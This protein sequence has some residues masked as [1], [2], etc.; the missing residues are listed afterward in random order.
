MLITSLLLSIA[1]PALAIPVDW[2]VAQGATNCSATD[3]DFSDSRHGLA[4][5][6]FSNAMSTSDGGLT[7]NVFPT[8]LQ[9]SLVFAKASS[10]TELYLARL[11]LYRSINGGSTWTEVGALSNNLGSV[12]DV[13]FDGL[14]RV[15]VQGGNLLRSNDSGSNWQV[16]FSAQENVNFNE[17]H[18]P[19]AMTGFASGGITYELGS[20][21]SVARTQDGGTTWTLLSFPHG[22]ITAADFMSASVG[23]LATLTSQVYVTNNGGDSWEGLT[24]LPDAAVLTDLAMRDASHWYATSLSGCIYETFNAGSSWVAS[25]CD[26]STRPL[27]A[28]TVKGGPAVAAGNSGLVYFENRVFRDG[29]N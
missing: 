12:F 7:W 28:I 26:P 21:G 4:S 29:F 8:G 16:A 19:T 27:A 3:V 10:T 13:H 20:Y 18:F 23:V 15:A 1:T 14:S 6:A 17:L 5:C 24:A 9:Q 22:Q 11:G 25:I 2:M